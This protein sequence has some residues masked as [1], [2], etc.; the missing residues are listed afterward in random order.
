MRDVGPQQDDQKRR[1]SG[2]STLERSHVHG[3][4]PAGESDGVEP[5]GQVTI[6]LAR[7]ESVLAS[8]MA[9]GWIV[10]IGRSDVRVC[11]V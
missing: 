3:P 10:A 5:R 9:V 1:R 4:G 8:G 2:G 11:L 6:F 7:W